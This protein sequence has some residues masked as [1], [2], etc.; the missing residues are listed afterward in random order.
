LVHEEFALVDG[1]HPAARHARRVGDTQLR[2][3]RMNGKPI[4]VP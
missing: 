3:A 4:T 1:Y 2:A